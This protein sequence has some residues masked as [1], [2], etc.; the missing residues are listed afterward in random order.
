MISLI[1]RSVNENN[2]DWFFASA[3]GEVS[4]KF[5]KK[6]NA[7]DLFKKKWFDISEQSTTF[8]TKNINF[9]FYWLNPNKR[10]LETDWYIILNDQTISKAYLF[11]IPKNTF[12]CDNFVSRS[13]IHEKLDIQIKYI[14]G[15]YI[16]MKSGILFNNYLVD[17]IEYK[18]LV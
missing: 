13:D 8:A 12:M 7:V 5:L 16:E 14:N 10:A 1:L 11:L 17:K 3:F 6:K 9:D 2:I 15:N 4:G 18:T